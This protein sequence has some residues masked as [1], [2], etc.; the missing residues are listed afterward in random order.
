MPNDTRDEIIEY[1]AADGH[2]ASILVLRAECEAA[3]V[4]LCLPAMGVA[5]AYYRDFGEAMRHL[6]VHVAMSDLRG[7][8]TSSL[9]ASRT[10]DFGYHQVITHDLP[11]FVAT[12]QKHFPKS[13]RYLFGHSLGGQL[14]SLFLSVNTEAAMGLIMM[15]SCNVYYKGWPRPA[16]YRV[17]A[18]ALLLRTIGIVLGH[19][20]GNSLGFAGN[21]ARTLITDW[22]N[23]CWS[24]KYLLANDAREFEHALRSLRKPILSMSIEGDPLAPQQSVDNLV[25]MLTTAT[26]TRKHLLPSVLGL[27]RAS[28]FSWIKQP[29]AVAELIKEWLSDTSTRSLP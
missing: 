9:R 18:T 29:F 28:H 15:A 22:F 20:P 24:G 5:A 23:N 11:T 10:C 8:G 19:I 3:P 4:L 14:W 17:L 7:I 6:G 12:I 25:A 21:E 2:R 26:L 13:D 27:M 1:M 16:R